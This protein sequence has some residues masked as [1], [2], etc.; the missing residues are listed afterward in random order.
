MIIIAGGEPELCCVVACCGAAWLTE[1]VG[2]VHARMHYACASLVQNVVCTCCALCREKCEKA[3]VWSDWRGK[4]THV[5][6]WRHQQ[7]ST[8]MKRW[9]CQRWRCGTHS[10]LHGCLLC[11]SPSYHWR[12]WSCNYTLHCSPSH[13]WTWHGMAC[14][15]GTYH[16]TGKDMVSELLRSAFQSS[17][18][19]GHLVI[20]DY[21]R[22]CAVALTI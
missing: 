21:M 3:F 10:L 1:R 22:I 15:V 14:N 4:L 8:S 5:K 17:N 7:W 18:P 19:I 12:S 20:H 13:I 11:F 2:S 6:G 9:M 16:A